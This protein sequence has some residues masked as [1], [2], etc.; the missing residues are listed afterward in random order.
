MQPEF[1][2][3]RGK[4]VALRHRPGNF[5]HFTYRRF[6]W[7]SLTKA[8]SCRQ[9][10]TCK[11]SHTKHRDCGPSLSRSPPV[12]IFC[13]W[14]RCQ[15]VVVSDIIFSNYSYENFICHFTSEDDTDLQHFHISN[16]HFMN[17]IRMFSYKILNLHIKYVIRFKILQMRFR[18]VK[19][20]FHTWNGRFTNQN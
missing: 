12:K 5:D 10:G 3:S 7:V 13:S 2:K 1:S 6:M 20:K 9:Q 14:T 15:L 18:L 4:T 19:H 16:F 8:R 17:E 11:I